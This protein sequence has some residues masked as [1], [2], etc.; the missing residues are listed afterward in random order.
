MKNG[1]F[2]YWIRIYVC[3][4]YLVICL[5]L[6]LYRIVLLSC[7]TII[8]PWNAT[9]QSNTTIVV[10][11]VCAGHPEPDFVRMAEARK[12]KLFSRNR[13][14]IV[15]W[16][17]TSSEKTIRSSMCEMIVKGKK[18]SSCMSYQNTLRKSYHHWNAQKSQSPRR[19][20]CTSSKTN[21]RKPWRIIRTFI[22]RWTD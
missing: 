16:V 10:I 18:C 2:K 15:A 13:D 4:N 19:H 1:S 21:F 12:G 5:R 6:W 8:G 20:H 9:G 22:L 7:Q 11:T 17:D 14:K 3:A